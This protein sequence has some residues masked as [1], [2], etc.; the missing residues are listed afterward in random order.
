[1]ATP[2]KAGHLRS[3]VHRVGDDP[4]G[5]AVD[6]F[7]DGEQPRAGLPGLAMGC[8]RELYS[9]TGERHRNHRR[10]DGH[11]GSRKVQGTKAQCGREHSLTVSEPFAAVSA[12]VAVTG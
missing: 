8:A 10:V 11:L 4:G 9:R 1:M 5:H 2:H 6:A 3:R 12:D 7:L